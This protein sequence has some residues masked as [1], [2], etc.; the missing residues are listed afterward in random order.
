[1]FGKLGNKMRG[2]LGIA[3]II[4][5]ILIFSIIIML[6]MGSAESRQ[7]RRKESKIT[8]HD[9]LATPINKNPVIP[10][11]AERSH[12]GKNKNVAKEKKEGIRIDEIKPIYTN[13]ETKEGV[14]I[15][16]MELVRATHLCNGKNEKEEAFEYILG[17]PK[18]GGCLK[19]FS[20]G[21][22][23]YYPPKTI[24]TEPHTVKIPLVVRSK[25][26]G[27]QSETELRVI[28]RRSG[29]YTF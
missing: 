19:H 22:M 12:P 8:E 28:I 23:R 24:K 25:E 4:G 10:T 27:C 29:S 16:L 9:E 5:G 26:D 1:M 20:K 13:V 18:G 6:F 15:N 11:S 21:H 14:Y 17:S 2:P 7:S 3:L